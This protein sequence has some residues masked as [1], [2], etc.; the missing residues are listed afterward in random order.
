MCCPLLNVCM[1]TFSRRTSIS[2]SHA[3]EP[4]GLACVFARALLL[5]V[6]VDDASPYRATT[7]TNCYAPRD[8]DVDGVG[9]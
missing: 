9:Y 5:R 2:R 6:C 8:V 3:L 1:L 7:Y 4:E